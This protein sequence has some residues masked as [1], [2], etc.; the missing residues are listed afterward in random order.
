SSSIA[1]SWSGSRPSATRTPSWPTRSRTPASG[2]S[3]W[4]STAAEAMS[5]PRAAMRTARALVLGGVVLASTG[6]A[7]LFAGYDVAPN[8]LSRNDDALRRLLVVGQ[9]EEA[10]ARVLPD[11]KA[12]PGDELLRALYAGIIAHH[13]GAYAE[14]H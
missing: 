11:G 1:S 2:S 14:S 4:K 5:L 6:C 9:A 12:A 13:A 3:S 10:Y 8:G 7:G